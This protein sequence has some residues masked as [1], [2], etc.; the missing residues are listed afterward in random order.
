MD[1]GQVDAGLGGDG[2]NRRGGDAV[3]LE[4]V[5]SRAQDLVLGRGVALEGGHGGAG[6][7]RVELPS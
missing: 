4:D 5:T 6:E 7:L 3:A 2:T 1:Q